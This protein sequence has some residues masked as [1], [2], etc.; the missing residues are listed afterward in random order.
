MKILSIDF[1]TKQIGL[2]IGD[3]DEKIPRSLAPI[4][5]KS[6]DTVLLRLKEIIEKEK[7]SLILLG[8]P[9]VN[10]PEKSWIFK[11]ILKFS[12]NLKK[13]IKTPLILFNEKDTSKIAKERN[14]NKKRNIHS[15]SSSILLERF[16]NLK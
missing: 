2:S 9:Q 6:I 16:L 14:K 10:N 12:L 4:S 1:G 3:L 13:K 5:A 8:I 7:I 15:L 11:K